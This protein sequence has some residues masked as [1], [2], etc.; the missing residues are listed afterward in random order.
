[1]RRGAAGALQHH[2]E[3]DP[4]K[5][6]TARPQIFRGLADSRPPPRRS[7]AVVYA[8]DSEPLRWWVFS[9]A[10][11]ALLAL[12]SFLMVSTWRYPSFKDIQP[13]AAPLS[14]FLPDLGLGHLSDPGLFPARA[15]GVYRWHTSV[16]ASR[17]RVGGLLRRRMRRGTRKPRRNRSINLAKARHGTRLAPGGN[18][19]RR[20][21]AG[22]R[23]PG[24]AGT[25]QK[26]APRLQL[27]SAAADG[28][29]DSRSR[30]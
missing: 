4:Q 16:A 20:H 29:T 21:A 10:W 5:S 19:R 23:D 3:S 25:K 6:R 17:I 30:F 26:P 13:D 24:A 22:P 18:R 11:L 15:A 12:L 14:D 28:S 8:S 9:A 27:V 1:M 7:A 2:Q